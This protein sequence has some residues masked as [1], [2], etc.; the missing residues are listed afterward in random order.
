MSPLWHTAAA[1]AVFLPLALLFGPAAG[2]AFGAAYYFGREGA[3]AQRATGRPKAET[4]WIPFTPWTWPR[5]MVLDAA[6]P[7]FVL[8][9]VATAWHAL[10]GVLMGWFL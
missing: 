6:V 4:W 3:E 10:D 7:A 9:V 5:Q 2:A 1:L 8:V